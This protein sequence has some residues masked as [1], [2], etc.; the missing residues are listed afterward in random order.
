VFATRK[1]LRA[2]KARGTASLS[3]WPRHTPNLS[4]IKRDVPPYPRNGPVWFQIRR[5]GQV[6]QRSGPPGRRGMGQSQAHATVGRLAEGREGRCQ[7]RQHIQAGVRRPDSSGLQRA[8]RAP[9]TKPARGICGRL[10][11]NKELWIPVVSGFH[12]NFHEY[13]RVRHLAVLSGLVMRY[14]RLLHN[15]TAM[16][17]ASG[18]PLTQASH[19][20]PTTA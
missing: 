7:R 10:L 15:G 8:P 2:R 19:S 13:L 16:T 9:A 12:T 4:S 5:K 14:L 1:A 17:L 11:G 6:M 20:H 3:A 18:C